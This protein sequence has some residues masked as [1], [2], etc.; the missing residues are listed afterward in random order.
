VFALLVIVIAAVIGADPVAT[1]F[2]G[3][4][5]LSAL[6]L[7]TLMTATCLAVIT[8]YRSGR[9]RLLGTGESPSWWIRVGAPGLGAIALAAALA[10][11]VANLGP[12]LAD[13][14]GV[15][16]MALPSV[17]VVAALA[18][19]GRAR[20]LRRHNRLAYA[21]IGNGQPLP[22]AVRDHAIADLEL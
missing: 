6:G 1:V 2:T 9:S 5:T 19:A 16:P 8:Y 14:S 21:A 17:V 15:A 13:P 3:L 10:V 20:W 22:L 7:L 11:T 18:G 12:T 4:A